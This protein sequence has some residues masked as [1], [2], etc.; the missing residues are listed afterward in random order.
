MFRAAPR[1]SCRRPSPARALRP[2]VASWALPRTLPPHI[3]AGIWYV[4]LAVTTNSSINSVTALTA[5]AGGE[6]SP[7]RGCSFWPAAVLVRG[8]RRNRA[9]LARPLS[10]EPYSPHLR[11]ISAVSLHAG[12]VL[13]Q[14]PFAAVAHRAGSYRRERVPGVRPLISPPPA[15]QKRVRA[16]P[17]PGPPVSRLWL[18]GSRRLRFLLLP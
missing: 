8:R 9:A 11:T 2:S 12:R 16:R 5:P 10:F 13:G 4:L 7:S 1:G 3:K 17:P 14:P 18:R 6:G 15:H